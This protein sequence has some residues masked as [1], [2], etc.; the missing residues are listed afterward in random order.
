[1]VYFYKGVEPSCEI[2]VTETDKK[3]E[4]NRSL[5]TVICFAGKTIMRHQFLCHPSKSSPL[6]KCSVLT[7]GR[8]K[9]VVMILPEYAVCLS[10]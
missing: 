10:L 8:Y 7:S 3:K 4:K 5:T 6:K 1:M 9:G 2:K